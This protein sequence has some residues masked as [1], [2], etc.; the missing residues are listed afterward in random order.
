ML[1]ERF[2]TE[3]VVNEEIAVSLT[4]RGWRVTPTYPVNDFGVEYTTTGE[5]KQLPKLNLSLSR[6][7]WQGKVTADLRPDIDGREHIYLM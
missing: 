5:T 6:E 7:S 1:L 3:Q 2:N 4:E